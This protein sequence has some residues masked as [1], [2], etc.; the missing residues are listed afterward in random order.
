MQKK[1]MGIIR[2]PTEFIKVRNS[3][4]VACTQGDFVIVLTE[5]SFCKGP[6]TIWNPGFWLV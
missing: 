5:C 1:Y 6:Q 3:A 4:I 2:M